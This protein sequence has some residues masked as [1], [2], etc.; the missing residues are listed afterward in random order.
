MAVFIVKA[1]Q[2]SAGF[3]K[4]KRNYASVVAMA[5]SFLWLAM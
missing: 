4:L 2:H 3:D 5:C 1:H